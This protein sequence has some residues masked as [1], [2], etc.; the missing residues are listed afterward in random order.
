MQSTVGFEMKV[1]AREWARR[2]YTAVVKSFAKTV[3][4]PITNSDTSFKRKHKLP[5]ASGLRDDHREA[6][7]QVHLYVGGNTHVYKE[8][9]KLKDLATKFAFG[10]WRKFVKNDVPPIFSSTGMKQEVVK[11]WLPRHLRNLNG[12]VAVS[13]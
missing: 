5:D 12:K 10:G 13:G 7:R 1:A 3:T 2:F 11:T 4:E 8:R 9:V 6:N